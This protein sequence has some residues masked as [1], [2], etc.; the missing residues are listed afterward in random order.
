MESLN[1]GTEM[2]GCNIGFLGLHGFAGKS[3]QKVWKLR[4][5]LPSY[6]YFRH[7][8]TDGNWEGMLFPF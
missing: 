5:L 8:I 4:A 1:D 3:S 2:R 6:H 7:T